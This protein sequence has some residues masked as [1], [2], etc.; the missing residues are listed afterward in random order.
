[1]RILGYMLPWSNIII[2]IQ[3]SNDTVIQISLYPKFV[4]KRVS[5]YPSL[6]VYMRICNL[7]PY[8]IQKHVRIYDHMLIGYRLRG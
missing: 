7:V 1:M 4:H 2:G 8:I 5:L 3:E 6:Y